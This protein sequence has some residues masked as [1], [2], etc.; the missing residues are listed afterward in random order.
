MPSDKPIHE[1]L[2]HLVN[3]LE[4]FQAEK[5]SQLEDVGRISNSLERLA[6]LIADLEV[7]RSRENKLTQKLEVIINQLERLAHRQSL[8]RAEVGKKDLELTLRKAIAGTRAVGQ[9]IEI[10]ANSAQVML[11]SILKTFN[12][13]KVTTAG[14]PAVS[15]GRTITSPDL[16]RLLEPIN[17]FLRSLISE[18]KKTVPEQAQEQ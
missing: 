10:I 8:E 16:S 9:V 2:D 15:T 11:D 12:D 7:Q 3:R 13:F 1:T 18:E 6:E 5:S 4:S 14:G 17:A